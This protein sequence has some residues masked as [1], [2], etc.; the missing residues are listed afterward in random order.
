MIAATR[1]VARRTARRLFIRSTTVSTAAPGAAV[2]ASSNRNAS[3]S[4]R[5]VATSSF[6]SARNVAKVG[7]LVSAAGAIYYVTRPASSSAL[8]PSASASTK[9]TAPAMTEPFGDEHTTA[10]LR[11]KQ[12]AFSFTLDS[13]PPPPPPQRIESKGFFSSRFKKEPP[14]AEIP[15]PAEPTPVV[16]YHTNQVA[17][18]DPIEDYHSEHR[19]SK[20]VIMGIYD[21]HSGTECAD[22]LSKYLG[23]YIGKAISELPAANKANRK[24]Q[25]VG[26]LKS[27]FKRMDHD[28]INGAIDL[29]T[30]TPHADAVA[31]MRSALRPAM[32]GSCAIV[33]YAEGNDLYVACTGDCR[34]VVARRRGDG[35]FEAVELSQDQ[36]A[37]NP[38]EYARLMEEHPNETNTVV[39]RGRVLGGLMP[40][41][42]FG[43]SRYKW[44]QE[45][46]AAIGMRASP[47]YLTP[48]YVTAEPE[49]TYYRMD[50]STDK[51]LII[52][53]D[54]I[55]DCL[56][57]EQAVD[58]LGGYMQRRGLV[59][60][61]PTV[62][63]SLLDTQTRAGGDWEWKD[64]N[65]ATHLIRNAIGR[66][67]PELLAKLVRI[68][69][70][71]SRRVRDDMTVNVVFFSETPTE[72][73]PAARALADSEGQ[74][75]LPQVDLALAG[76]KVPRFQMWVKGMQEQVKSNL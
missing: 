13:L 54:G 25:V 20:G 32:A 10:Y 72:E 21:G 19:L 75:P 48:P 73:V 74:V 63:R 46:K 61:P 9:S 50:P 41:R 49:V 66:G 4:P 23:A 64:T 11:Q 37:A 52:A 59:S 51:A 44:L 60:D 56:S 6:L 53:T 40:T 34:A 76:E 7:A 1:L 12:Q 28:I 36:T 24:A 5:P 58:L 47:A 55:W 8:S 3:T 31:A 27:A 33:A 65:A 70:P 67:N 15:P 43:D 26:A 14:V 35:S 38:A 17:S 42:A 29:D 30:S 16:A 57:S 71:Y 2:L 45:E 18:N 69:A 62:G 39:S 68:P 22:A